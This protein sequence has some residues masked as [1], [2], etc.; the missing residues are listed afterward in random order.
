MQCPACSK[1]GEDR[2]IDSRTTDGGKAIRR[3]RECVACGRRFTTKE[4][5]EEDNRITVIKKDGSRMPFDPERV[6]NGMR[7]A[8]Y[9]RPVPQK[10]LQKVVEMIEDEIL[11]NFEREVP[12]RAIGSM[13]ARHL[14][15]LD[16]VAY[17]R[18]ASVYRE[19]QGLDDMIDEIESVKEIA[20]DQVPGQQSLFEQE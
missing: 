6:L 9:K 11:K 19:F 13:V 10:V 8:C 18:F 3:R 1:V 12:S 5:V 7:H 4:R 16:Q 2:V 14:R 20:H 17:V 15:E